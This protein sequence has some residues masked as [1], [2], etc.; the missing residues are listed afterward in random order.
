MAGETAV[1]SAAGAATGGPVGAALPWIFK[2]ASLLGGLF[3]G[4]LCGMRGGLEGEASPAARKDR[5]SR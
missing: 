5:I 1:A 2:G 4:G 3:A